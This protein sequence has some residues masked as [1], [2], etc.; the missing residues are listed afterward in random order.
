MD[1]IRKPSKTFQKG[2]GNNTITY[3]ITQ[4][5]IDNLDNCRLVNPIVGTTEYK[6]PK[7]FDE[8]QSSFEIL[9]VV[10]EVKKGIFPRWFMEK[11]YPFKEEFGEFPEE[12][13]TPLANE[14][15]SFE[16]PVGLAMSVHMDFPTDMG[17]AIIRWLLSEGYNVKAWTPKYVNFLESVPFLEEQ[18]SDATKRALVDAFKGKYATGVR[19]P[20]EVLEEITGVPGPLFTLYPEGSP[21]HPSGLFAGHGAASAASGKSIIKEFEELPNHI[22]KQVLDT[23]YI[24]AMSRSLAGVHHWQDNVAS[25]VAFGLKKY[26]KKE[27][28]SLFEY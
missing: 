3:P 19:R 2:A 8:I 1:N 5:Q 11:Y 10:Q 27:V 25:L 16:D 7:D 6:I 28:I 20:E 12:I 4:E 17:R 18:L 15:L 23:C 26:I 22:L 13:P 9:K 24:W 21:C 14:G